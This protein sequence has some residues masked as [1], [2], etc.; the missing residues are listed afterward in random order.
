MTWPGIEGA[1][2]YLIGVRNGGVWF[3]RIIDTEELHARVD[4]GSSVSVAAIDARGNVSLF[5][6]EIAFK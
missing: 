1:V 5:S 2:G 4:E 3:E 6:P